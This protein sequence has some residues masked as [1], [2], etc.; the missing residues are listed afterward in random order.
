VQGDCTLYEDIVWVNLLLLYFCSRRRAATES[1][2]PSELSDYL[3]LLT[4]TPTDLRLHL[5]EGCFL[6]EG[7]DMPLRRIVY[8]NRSTPWGSC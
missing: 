3:N 5:F 7:V 8:M 6:F 1:L 2:C 4:T